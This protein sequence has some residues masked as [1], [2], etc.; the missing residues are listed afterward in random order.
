MVRISKQS[1][2]TL[3]RAFVGKCVCLSGWWIDRVAT[4]VAEAVHVHFVLCLLSQILNSP[5]LMLSLVTSH[6]SG[7]CFGAL[8]GHR[9]DAG[10]DVAIG[11]GT[12]RGGG[13][14]GPVGRAS[15]DLAAA[16]RKGLL[17]NSTPFSGHC[18]TYFHTCFRSHSTCT[19]LRVCK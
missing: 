3:F 7:Y 11:V 10:I 9:E 12:Y 15:D 18:D 14:N 13:P 17:L 2:G 5:S 1:E 6:H 8:L 4:A 19:L 16:S